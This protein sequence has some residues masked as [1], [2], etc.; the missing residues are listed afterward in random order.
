MYLVSRYKFHDKIFVE[1]N[2]LNLLES[3]YTYLSNI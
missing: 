1:F 3:R 2:S